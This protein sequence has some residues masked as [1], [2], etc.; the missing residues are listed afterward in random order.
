M[1]KTSVFIL[2]GRVLKN[3]FR[4]PAT[5]KYPFEPVDLRETLGEYFK[6]DSL[7]KGWIQLLPGIHRGD[8]FFIS[9]F[10]RAD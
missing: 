6:E 5:T 9:V 4:E 3:L 10:R 7:E 1:K 2:A 8:G